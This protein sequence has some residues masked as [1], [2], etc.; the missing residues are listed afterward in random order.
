M[1]GL[2]ERRRIGNIPGHRTLIMIVAFVVAV[3]VTLI[4]LAPVAAASSGPTIV[5]TIVTTQQGL[6]IRM[7]ERAMK[8]GR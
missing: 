6:G 3:M 8:D 5:A 1:N 7:R 2:V 4:P